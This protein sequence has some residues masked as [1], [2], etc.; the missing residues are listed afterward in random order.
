MLVRIRFAAEVYIEAD[1]VQE[2]RDKWE[3]LPL[4]SPEALENSAE[5]IE[6]EAIEDG[7]TSADIENE[8]YKR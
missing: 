5:F 4:F 7:D 6:T 3:N 1:S 2:A 8:W